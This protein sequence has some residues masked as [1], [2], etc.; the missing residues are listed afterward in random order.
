VDDVQRF[1]LDGAPRRC[2]TARN[3]GSRP[4]A[5]PATP[6][7]VAHRWPTSPVTIAND[8]F[9]SRN[10]SR[11]PPMTTGSALNWGRLASVAL[12]EPGIS[13]EVPSRIRAGVVSYVAPYFGRD[14]ALYPRSL[15]RSSSMAWDPGGSGSVGKKRSHR[16]IA[17][18]TVVTSRI[19]ARGAQVVFVAASGGECLHG[20]DVF[21]RG[22]HDAD[23]RMVKDFAPAV[24]I[25][26]GHVSAGLLVE[27]P[28]WKLGGEVFGYGGQE[29]GS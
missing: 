23:T 27:P 6:V 12:T 22:G 16:S 7:A 28:R 14:Q 19:F 21:R 3:C 1:L 11:N 24:V 10:P 9:P 17:A 26:G 13:S 15:K 4:T 2:A 8:L 18:L 5:H 20:E 29:D 25:L